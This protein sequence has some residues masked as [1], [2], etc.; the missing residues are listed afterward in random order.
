MFGL[1]YF[2][3][4]LFFDIKD[5][6]K[7][8]IYDT[9]KKVS[10]VFTRISFGI[11]AIGVSLLIMRYGFEMDVQHNLW[12]KIG[13]NLCFIFYLCKFLTKLIYREESLKEF[14]KSN[15]FESSLVVVFLFLSVFGLFNPTPKEHF[16]IE[17]TDLIAQILLI[18]FLVIEFGRA[19]SRLISLNLPPALFFVLSF[20]VLILIGSLLLMLPNATII[21]GSMPWFEALF[22]SIS[23]GCVTGLTLQDTATYFTSTGHLIL[24]ILIQLGG[25]NIISFASILATLSRNKLSVRHQ[26]LVQQS[27]SG[28]SLKETNAILHR[29][30]AYTFIIELIGAILIYCSWE[31]PFEEQSKKIFYSIFHSISGFNNAGF[32]LFSNNA[33]EP[34]LQF[35]FAF[36]IPLMFLVFFGGIGFGTL[37]Q[38]LRPSVLKSLFRKKISQKQRLDLNAKMSLYTSGLL[39]L[40]G[41]V[42]L[43]FFEY[44]NQ[45]YQT[46]DFKEKILTSFFQSVNARTAGFNNIDLSLLT[47]SSILILISLMF[48]GASPMSTGGGIKTTTIAM[49]FLST[50]NTLRGRKHIHIHKHFIQRSFIAKAL[51]IFLFAVNFLFLTIL[52]LSYTDPNLPILHLIFEQVSAFCT[53]GLSMGITTDLSVTGKTILMVSMFV[54]RV[55]TLTLGYALTKKVVRA[56]YKYP[57]ANISVG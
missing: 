45:I 7:L 39:I 31:I 1:F 56:D 20:V 53:V 55:G 50:V 44:N 34:F 25:L 2:F 21:E 57:S 42:I 41:A 32:S 49:L 51:A 46:M 28:N 9:R 14:L 4:K 22:T 5:Y 18:L 29:I 38:M 8:F 37:K 24:M 52:I 15:L 6:H 47:N 12:L 17:Y 54:G 33:A 16:K 11:A 27:V 26:T 48:I 43:L 13:L 3:R 10:R 30:F 40:V 19:G 35:N 23:A 36:Q